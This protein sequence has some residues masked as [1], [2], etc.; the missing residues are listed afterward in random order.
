M[1][2]LVIAGGGTGGHLYPGVAVAEYVKQFGVDSFFIVSKRGLERKV[3]TDLG[4]PFYEQSE[5]P[6]NGVSA[7]RKVKSVFMLMKEVARCH[8]LLKKDDKLLL[9]GGFVSAAAALVGSM[10]GIEMY[11]HEQNSVMGMTNRKFA[12]SCEKVFLSFPDTK[13]AVGKTTVT[14][15]PVR[16]MFK[17]IPMKEEAGKN[18]LIL[19]GSQGSRFIN[20]QVAEAAKSLL[21]AG[22][23]I[24]HQAGGKLLGET[25]EK[26]NG[27]GITP[28]E[29]LQVT[30]YIDDVAEALEWA[31]VVIARSGSGTVFE[32]M[33][34]KR[35]AL[36]IPFA[37]SA[38]EHQ[39][40][41]AKF[42]EE[43]GVAKVLTEDDAKP[44]ALAGMVKSI[45]LNYDSYKTALE[46]LKT[47]ES[48]E[49]I[50]GGMN[51]G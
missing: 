10:K 24:R 50:A 39:L 34:A 45:S 25:V 14:G 42:A 18:I 27:L 4:Y 33:N 8:R 6:L 2:R 37:L 9:T 29:R 31:D 35:V 36:Y 43:Q 30:G 28:D 20:T 12:G 41:N 1:S 7:L 22:F 46:N 15:N 48:V 3:L 11:L 21:E 26:Y 19:G 47:Y 44:E 49:L 5:T 40:Y 16:A 51:I 38:D 32:V 13:K 17:N 23:T